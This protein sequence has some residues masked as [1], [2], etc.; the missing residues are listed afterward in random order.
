MVT[1]LKTFL[2]ITNFENSQNPR[3]NPKHFLCFFCSV[4]VTEWDPQKNKNR[5]E[6]GQNPIFRILF[7]LFFYYH[8]WCEKLWV[9]LTFWK[10]LFHLQNIGSKYC[11]KH[12]FCNDIIICDHIWSQNISHFL[13]CDHKRESVSKCKK[14]VF[15]ENPFSYSFLDISKNVQNPKPKKTFGKSSYRI[16]WKWI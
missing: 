2:N 16:L 9:K 14:T 3:E 11:K 6:K 8:I 4:S 1:M 15:S 10:Q 7:V 5:T 13:N 12:S